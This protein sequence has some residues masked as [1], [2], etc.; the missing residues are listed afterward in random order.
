MRGSTLESSVSKPVPCL[1]YPFDMSASDFSRGNEFLRNG[2]LEEA[3]AAYQNAIVVNPDFYLAYHNLGEALE[4]LGRFDEAVQAYQ[5]AVEL[6]P[7]AAWSYLSLSRVLRQVGRVE[8]AKKAGDRAIEIEPKLAASSPVVNQPQVTINPV[9]PPV[10]LQPATK[11]TPTVQSP[12]KTVPAEQQIQPYKIILF[13]P[14][15]KAKQPERQQ[16]LIYCLQKNIECVEI[17]KIF[18]L[19]DDG[20]QPELTSP[21]IEI[22]NL[23][24]RPTYLNW[25]ELTQEKY[26]DQISVLANTDIYFDQSV[27]RLREIFSANPKAFVTISRYEQEGSAQTLHKNPHWSQDVWAIFGKNKLLTPALKNTLKIPLGVPRCDNKIAYLFSIYGAKVYNPCLDIKTFHVQETDSRTYDKKKDTSVLGTVAYVHPSPSILKYSKLDFELWAVDFSQIKQVQLN[28]SLETWEKETKRSGSKAASSS[29]KTHQTY[30]PQ[31]DCLLFPVIKKELEDLISYFDNIL[32]PT[33]EP[34]S[35]TFVISIDQ[36]WNDKDIKIVQEAINNSPAQACIKEVKFIAC[37]LQDFES[38]YIRDIPTDISTMVLPAYGLKTG[39]NL[40]FFR[41]MQKLLNS[42]TKYTGVL[43]QEVDT[44]PLKNMWVDLINKDIYNLKDALVI[45][46]K[47][48]GVSPLKPEQV[49]HL[50]GNA[51]YGLAHPLF[52]RFLE[53]WERL[54]IQVAKKAPWKAYD[55]ATEWV[56]QYLKDDSCWVLDEKKRQNSPYFKSQELQEYLKIYRQQTYQLNRVIN[57]AGPHELMPETVFDPAAITDDLKLASVLHLRPALPFRDICRYIS[58]EQKFLESNVIGYDGSWQ[59]PAITEKHAYKMAQKY[60]H[61]YGRSIVYFGF[62]W[63][64]LIDQFLHKP[65]MTKHLL[66]VL[67]RYKPYLQQF[68]KVVTV[69]QHVKMLDYQY[70]FEKVGIT[71]IFWS[72]AIKGQPH[73]TKFPEIKIHPFP[74]F[75]AQACD[76]SPQKLRG[77]FRKLLFCFVGSKS[78]SYYLTD[79]RNQIIKHLSNDK[80]GVIRSRD[81]WHYRDIVY[82]YQIKKTVT[83]E[84]NLIDKS[85]TFEFKELLKQ[86]VFSL[87]PSGSGPNSI[88]LWESIGYG[89][90]PVVLSDTYLPPGDLDLWESA[91]VVC[92]EKSHEI[93]ALPDRL[94]LLNKDK[95]S[96]DQKKDAL[97]VLWDRYGVGCFIY[98]IIGLFNEF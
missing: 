15:Y 87:C 41:S 60:L 89:S 32:L 70:L 74:L 42:D 78:P 93:K 63:A 45:G 79:S 71:D 69:C 58:N 18:L 72:H 53:L 81:V 51:V 82:E 4:K 33:Q 10:S 11:V 14:Y 48:S 91:V 56:I 31:V 76:L 92:P 95:K 43:L 17:A 49:N 94:E 29:P 5:K 37:E 83:Y 36:T 7:E 73:L 68:S 65:E 26:P 64:T 21:K 62:P 16:E 9:Q 35:L 86:S 39:P 98:D 20:H 57:K 28:K 30:H 52:K 24:S 23:A 97:Q 75:P 13:T 61:G 12:A 55:T 77:V 84:K 88:R 25:V 38:I 50:N 1:L 46:S 85:H 90:I 34:K 8:E 96:L 22:L 44:I 54:V 6:K 27:S 19:I 2:Q 59:Y 3:I 66:L 80:R 47:Y 40:Q 67:E